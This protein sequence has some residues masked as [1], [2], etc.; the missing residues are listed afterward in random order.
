MKEEVGSV[1]VG[2]QTEHKTV[3]VLVSLVEVG[4]VDMFETL[5]LEFLA[6]EGGRQ[7]AR[8]DAQD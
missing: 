4:G 1:P 3:S 8:V 5:H 6:K 2:N 7:F